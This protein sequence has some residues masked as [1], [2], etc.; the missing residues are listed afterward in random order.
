[1]HEVSTESLVER[2]YQSL[3]HFALSLAR[4]EVMAA[5]LTQ[6]T[7]YL[8]SAKGHQLR[9]ATK[10]KAWLFTTLHREFLRR[11]Q[12]SVRF[13][14]HEASTVEHELPVVASTVEN[15]LDATAV[16]QA[17]QSVDE[18]YRVPLAMFYL[19]DFSYNEI[20]EAL[21]VPAGTVMSRLARGK[22]QLR[23][24]LGESATGTQ[25]RIVRLP[26][27]QPRANE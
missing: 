20:A 3:Y 2:F 8:W 17:L 18:I 1:M 26:E 11:H 19:E 13:P 25:N 4:S 10:V 23:A 15:Q 12:H 9:D 16:M 7:F 27:S 5:D 14:H 21:E 24:L 22:A 6:E